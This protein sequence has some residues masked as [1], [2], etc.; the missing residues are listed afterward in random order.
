MIKNKHVNILGVG[1]STINMKMALDQ[2]TKCIESNQFHYICVTGVHGI[3]EAQKDETFRSILNHAFLNVPDGMPTVWI[4]RWKGIR[5]MNRVC[6]PDFM[7][8]MMKVATKKGYTNYFYGGK[9]GVSEKLRD[10]LTA[11]FPGLK[12]VGTCSPP[13]RKLTDEEEK[14]LAEDI[15]RVKPDLFWVGFST[16]KQEHFMYAHLGKIETK[17]MIGV[18]AAFDFNA[19]LVKRA[20]KWMQRISL[21]WFYRLCMEP[22]RL[23]KRYL[24]NNPLFVW[25]FALQYFKIR[26][27]GKENML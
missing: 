18:G 3:M 16:P 7:L 9:P 17:V 6:G 14:R 4:G 25:N 23:W 10:R 13:F 27:Y 11:K 2:I 24:V 19:G 21:E 8:E 26:R 20:P 12:V 15:R 1:I 22:R 5:Y